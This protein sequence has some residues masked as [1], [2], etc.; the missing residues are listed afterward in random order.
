MRPMTSLFAGLFAFYFV[1][2]AIAVIR[3][4]HTKWDGVLGA[5]SKITRCNWS[6]YDAMTLIELAEAVTRKVKRTP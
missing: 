1:R 2:L 5:F 3:L 4:R 6:C